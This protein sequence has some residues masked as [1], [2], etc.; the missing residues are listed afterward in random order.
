[1]VIMNN[2]NSNINYF[3]NGSECRYLEIGITAIPTYT[4]NNPLVM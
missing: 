4:I 3:N 1:M 2:N